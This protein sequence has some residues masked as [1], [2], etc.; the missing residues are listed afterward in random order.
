MLRR[1]A[2]VAAADEHRGT[3]ARG[4]GGRR[5]VEAAPPPLYKLAADPATYA[6]DFNDVTLG[7]NTTDP[8]VPGYPA[9]TGWDPVT[10]LGTPNAAALLPDLVTAARTG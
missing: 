1:K 6:A 9:T 7:N 10:G 4:N 5:T 3:D 2:L 8:T